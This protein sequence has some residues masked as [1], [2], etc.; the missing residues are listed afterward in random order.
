MGAPCVPQNREKDWLVP[1]A[2]PGLSLNRDPYIIHLNIALEIVIS[3]YFGG[4]SCVSNGCK[5]YLL[6]SPAKG[7]SFLETRA[8]IGETYCCPLPRQV[9]RLFLAALSAETCA[10]THW[11]MIHVKTANSPGGEFEKVA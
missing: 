10:E 2:K 7:K 11:P 6:R 3:F 4:K 8:S 1:W 9:G 5:M